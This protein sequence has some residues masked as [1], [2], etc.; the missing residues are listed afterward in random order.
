MSDATSRSGPGGAK[1][2]GALVWDLPTRLFHW[3]LAAAVIGAWATGEGPRQVHV[4]CGYAIIVLIVF[5]LIWGVIGG[6]HARFTDFVRGPTAVA[7]HLRELRDARTA[8]PEAGHNAAGGWMVLLLLGLIGLQVTLGLFTDDDILFVGPLGELVS[9][10]TRLQITAIHEVLGS[11]LPWVI[12]IHVAA[13][14]LYWI[15][16]RQNLIWPMITGYKPWVSPVE[17]TPLPPRAG[18][19]PRAVL[20]LAVGIAVVVAIMIWGG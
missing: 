1:P 6:R 12:G 17:V 20:A 13:V 19:L 16:R 4:W 10:D 7:L 2:K 9:Y 14:L 3:L 15:A 18:S 8:P 5:R 11:I